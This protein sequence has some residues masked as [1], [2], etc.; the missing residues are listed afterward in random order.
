MEMKV[1]EGEQSLK[2][3][4]IKNLKELKEYY[5]EYTQKFKDLIVVEE[6]EK[7]YK[8]LLKELTQERKPLKDARAGVNKYLTSETKKILKDIDEVTDL[9]NNVIEPIKKALDNLTEE[10][11]LKRIEC[12]KEVTKDI[13]KELN[14]CICTANKEY[15][16]DIEFVLFDEKWVNMKDD[17]IFQLI[18]S[19]T[20]NIKRFIKTLK[21][22]K[23][24]VDIIAEKFKN[25]YDLK[26]RIDIENLDL[27]DIGSIEKE[28][29]K[30]AIR[31]QEI[32]IEAEEKIK[33][34]IKRQQEKKEKEEEE[35]KQQE[36]KRQQEIAENKNKNDVTIK[37]LAI[38][39]K[40][41]L[42]LL[43]FIKG[44]KINY[45]VV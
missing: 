13:L 14:E 1:L 41:A 7:E 39:K 2:F 22:N 26:S 19:E 43:E 20:E 16:L 37:F 45:K 40:Q 6:Q 11:R 30:R 25:E 8:E 3:E 24:M 38:T 44:N 34:E 18:Y 21:N 9:L 35:K 27:T 31:Q 29:E 12:K 17:D 4:G 28:L 32:E 42:D 5:K 23:K 36:L 10:R 33:E 15:K